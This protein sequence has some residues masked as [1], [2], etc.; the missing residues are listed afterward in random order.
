MTYQV[1]DTVVINQAVGGGTKPGMVGTVHATIG[2][3]YCVVFSDMRLGA[4]AEREGHGP[5][6]YSVE[7]HEMYPP[8]VIEELPIP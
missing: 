2:T 5:G 8:A 3:I 1:G 4:Y 7:P 6:H